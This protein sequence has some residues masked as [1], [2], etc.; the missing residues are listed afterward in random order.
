MEP[1]FRYPQVYTVGSN[2][3]PDYCS[4]V[5]A[6]P[7]MVPT[8]KKRTTE[9]QK[10]CTVVILILALL[11][12]AGMAFGSFYLFQLHQK[13]NKLKQDQDSE[14]QPEKIIGSAE[15]SQSTEI[16][17]HVT[18]MNVIRNSNTLVWDAEKGLALTKG[19]SY[20]AGALVINEAGNYLI[21]SKVFFRGQ[22]CKSDISLEHTVFKRTKLYPKDI[23][24][25]VNSNGNS[26]PDNRAQWTRSSFQSGIFNLKQNDHIY[27]NVSD[28][29][30]VSFDQFN[31]YFGLHKL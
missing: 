27:V 7:V 9:W 25:M 31:T 13:L 15:T 1:D 28:P 14:G 10:A 2:L 19:V 6:L 30:F 20:D 11:I 29:K 23:H 21:Y 3:S 8:M 22:E 17:A 18:G 4:T 12:L 5:S 16:V 24:L 26:C